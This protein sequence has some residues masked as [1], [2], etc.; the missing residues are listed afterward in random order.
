VSELSGRRGLV[1]PRPCGRR[2][3]AA[4]CVRVFAISGWTASS[5]P[6]FLKK[7]IPAGPTNC[8][9]AGV[10]TCRSNATSARRDALAALW[11]E[12]AIQSE[13]IRLVS[14]YIADE[15][16]DRAEVD[17]SGC[18]FAPSIV[19]IAELPGEIAALQ[20]RSASTVCDLLR[21]HSHGAKL[22]F[23]SGEANVRYS[24]LALQI[25]RLQEQSSRPL[26]AAIDVAARVLIPQHGISIE[27]YQDDPGYKYRCKN[28]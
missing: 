12:P 18:H 20:A 3:H 1:L 8:G 24:V 17:R 15:G 14:L 13:P 7:P 4:N 19:S 28:C 5:R 2:P 16:T 11:C 21:S 10:A 23:V 26:D 25:R 9:P 22:R 27:S 6:N